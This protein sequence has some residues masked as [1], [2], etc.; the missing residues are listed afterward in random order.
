MRCPYPSVNLSIL[1]IGI[2][3]C[4][5]HEY[6]LLSED[7]ESATLTNVWAG[8]RLSA[9]RKSIANS[10]RSCPAFC[11]V[12]NGCDDIFYPATPP[13]TPIW[14]RRLEATS[15][16]AG[17]AGP[18]IVQID[19]DVSCNLA[20]VMC[21]VR[22]SG[23]ARPLDFRTE[24]IVVEAC[25][26]CPELLLIFQGGEPFY[27]HA[28][29]DFARRITR[30]SPGVRFGFI[31]NALCWDPAL[32]DDLPTAGF[33]VSVDG[34]TG[35]T[36]ERIRCGG[37]W[38]VL[39]RNLKLLVA[40]CGSSVPLQ[41]NFTVMS[42]NVHEMFTAAQLLTDCGVRRISYRPVLL[43]SSHR[44]FVFARQAMRTILHAQCD[45]LLQYYSNSVDTADLG[46][47]E[48]L[49]NH[50]CA[51]VTAGLEERELWSSMEPV[52][53]RTT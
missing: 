28:T 48:H 35:R 26:R 18:S 34:G 38:N 53:V 46:V 27:H 50:F 7:L 2:R 49:A 23:S 42:S 25:E 37:N 33:I 19:Y 41:V 11:P 30:L 4:C 12:M 29:L 40:S 31:T 14:R 20:C 6:D 43:N 22:L 13:D 39:L 36:Y 16:S 47:L 5:W 44:E 3:P 1:S 51:G 52:Q 15:L 9:F 8:T 45:L 24:K 21:N 10:Q 17:S 32:T